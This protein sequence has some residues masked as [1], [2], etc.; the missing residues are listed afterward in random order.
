MFLYYNISIIAKRGK[1]S[2]FVL[3]RSARHSNHSQSFGD[4][5]GKHCKVIS[6]VIVEN[7]SSKTPTENPSGFNFFS[8]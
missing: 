4:E 3:K 7:L 6:R 2:P 8:F 5:R 1:F